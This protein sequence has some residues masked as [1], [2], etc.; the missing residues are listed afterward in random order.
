VGVGGWI[1]LAVLAAALA[2]YFRRDRKGAPAPP[3]APLPED[4]GL[5]R[6]EKAPLEMVLGLTP[7]WQSELTPKLDAEGWR[8]VGDFS[9]TSTT[10]FF[11]RIFLSPDARTALLFVNWVEGKGGFKQVVTNLE[12]YSFLEDGTFRLTAASQD[13]AARLLTGANRPPEG[14]L[15]LKL[16]A[17]FSELDVRPL[18][19]AHAEWVSGL[20][21]VRVLAKE[22]V[23]EGLSGVFRL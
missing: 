15:R 6:L 22:S 10:F 21:G 7:K 9:Y 23:R 18:M 4:L 2:W 16:Q 3:E 19:A 20:P 14:H 5:I 11:A 1:Y 13:G 8:M 17:V 12:M